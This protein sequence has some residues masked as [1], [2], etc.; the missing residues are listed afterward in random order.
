MNATL[1]GLAMLGGALMASSNGDDSGSGELIKALRSNND[2][3]RELLANA[4][5]DRSF[6]GDEACELIDNYGGGA[7][8][9]IDSLDLTSRGEYRYEKHRADFVTMWKHF[10]F[11]CRGEAMPDFDPSDI[12]G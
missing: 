9:I 1:T 2:L 8:D 10:L 7:M 12:S 3:I 6:E 4:K 5:L 11:T